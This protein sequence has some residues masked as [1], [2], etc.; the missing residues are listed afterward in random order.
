[1]QYPSLWE[2]AGRGSQLDG[3]LPFTVSLQSHTSRERLTSFTGCWSL[4]WLLPFRFGF[5][6]SVWS[7]FPCLFHSLVDAT[8]DCLSQTRRSPAKSVWSCGRNTTILKGL[9]CIY[10]EKPPSPVTQL[11]V[12]GIVPQLLMYVY[13]RC[14]GPPRV[15]THLL[16]PVRTQAQLRQPVGSS[17]QVSKQ[18]G[19][20]TSS[21]RAAIGTVPLLEQHT[22]HKSPRL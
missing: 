11:Q 19:T 4:L 3:V 6:W 13:H 14:H 8:P 15:L 10:E 1:M 17:R 9:W 21:L 2:A 20:H 18:A 12:Y 16:I 7:L 5:C 22:Y